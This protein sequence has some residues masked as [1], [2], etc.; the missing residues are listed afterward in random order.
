[1]EKEK[2]KRSRRNSQKADKEMDQE[3]KTRLENHIERLYPVETNKPVK[4][5]L[6]TNYIQKNLM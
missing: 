6:E 3:M 2:K 1:M 5:K 4:S